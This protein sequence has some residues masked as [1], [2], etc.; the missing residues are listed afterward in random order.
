VAAAGAGVLV[1]RPS[2][3]NLFVVAP[4]VG[5]NRPVNEYTQS[6]GEMTLSLELIDGGTGRVVAR[7]LDHR[8]DR[9]E[10]GIFTLSNAST[11]RAALRRLMNEWAEALSAVIGGDGS[12]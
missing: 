8:A 10:G 9:A 1:V 12:G 6:A 3:H 2:I 5:S 7:A 11:N 4:D